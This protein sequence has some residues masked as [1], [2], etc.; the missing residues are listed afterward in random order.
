MTSKDCIYLVGLSAILFCSDVVTALLKSIQSIARR[1][2][3]KRYYPT[4]PVK[5]NARHLLMP[6]NHLMQ[7]MRKINST[8]Y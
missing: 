5:L 1:Q 7:R 6:A 8:Y 3:W 4:L 2:E